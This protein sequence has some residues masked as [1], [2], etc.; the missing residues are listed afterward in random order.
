[1]MDYRKSL[2]LAV[3][4]L[5]FMGAGCAAQ[6]PSPSA[7]ATP[8]S[9]VPA[10]VPAPVAEVPKGPIKFSE[11]KTDLMGLSGKYSALTFS[12][13]T[14]TCVSTLPYSELTYSPSGP[15]KNFMLRDKG[16]AIDDRSS[17]NTGS[18]LFKGKTVAG[19]DV[20]CKM[21]IPY[22]ADTATLTCADAAQKEVCAGTYSISAQPI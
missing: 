16:V 15:G 19:K 20:D 6:A 14:G 22:A 18:V 11:A 2:G 21:L 13:A 3:V 9:R 10:T 5:A 8:T 17:S 12:N 7:N 1:M 4:A